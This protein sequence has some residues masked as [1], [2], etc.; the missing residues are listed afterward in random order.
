MPAPETSLAI[1]DGVLAA[2]GLIRESRKHR[3]ERTDQGLY[4]L[5]AA[6]NE[7]K[8]YIEVLD[9]GK[10]RDRKRERAIARLWHDASVPLRD[11]DP[12]LAERCFTKGSFWLEPDAWTDVMI[13]RKRIK[14]DQVLESTRNL[15][16]RN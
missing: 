1:F 13:K 4:A 11:I 15:L 5:Y 6:L 10:K 12:D 14:L 3:S 8:A 7:T 2:I 16:M 9:S